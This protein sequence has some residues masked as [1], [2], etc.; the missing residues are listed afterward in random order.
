MLSSLWR[1]PIWNKGLQCKHELPLK[2]VIPFTNLDYS[3]RPV[4]SWG[5]MEPLGS[6]HS[7]YIQNV[8]RANS[9]TSYSQY[10]IGSRTPLVASSPGPAQPFIAW[11]TE[12]R[13]EPGI[14]LMY[15]WHNRQMTKKFRTKSV[16]NCSTNYKFNTRCVT[17]S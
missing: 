7:K 15:G 3:V 4:A 13:G 2:F 11:G 1:W 6:V 8:G 10:Y 12:N 5:L 16:S 9:I 14:F 17:V